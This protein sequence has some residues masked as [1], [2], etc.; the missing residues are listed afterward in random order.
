M[1]RSESCS[2]HSLVRKAIICFEKS[3]SI[4]SIQNVLL[5]LWKRVTLVLLIAH[6]WSQ[7]RNCGTSSS[8]TGEIFGFNP[9]SF[10]ALFLF[11]TPSCSSSFIL[12]LTF[13]SVFPPYLT[14]PLKTWKNSGLIV[15]QGLMPRSGIKGRSLVFNP[16][17]PCL[18]QWQSQ[19][20]LILQ[21]NCIAAVLSFKYSL[22]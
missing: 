12:T 14:A 4:L 16:P 8:I 22:P 20:G 21:S 11:L 6:N 17:H 1:K 19:W 15:I 13:P 10:S 2:L 9:F 18:Q 7:P 3:H 5:W